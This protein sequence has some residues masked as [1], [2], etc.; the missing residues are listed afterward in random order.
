MRYK[1]IILRSPVL[2]DLDMLFKWENN[3]EIWQVSN[4]HSPYTLDEIRQHIKDSAM[5]VFESGQ[6]RFIICLAEDSKPIGTID[7]FDFDHYNSRIGVGVLI[8]DESNRRKGYARMSVD[9]IIDYCFKRLHLH[10]V[11]CNILADN[12]ASIALFEG[13]GFNC[14]GIKREWVLT[15]N[16]YRDELI[17]QL[18]ATP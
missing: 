11:Y 12:K 7:L 13:A 17:Y 15:E 6:A 1:D 9:A 3:R 14:S 4:T 18:I 2:E 16:G 5:T 8:A 10:Q